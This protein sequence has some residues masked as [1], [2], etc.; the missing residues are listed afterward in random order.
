[1]N[2][3]ITKKILGFKDETQTFIINAKPSDTNRQFEVRIVDELTLVDFTDVATAI[4]YYGNNSMDIIAYMN[5]DKSSFVIPL[6]E[7]LS[8]TGDLQCEIVL[9][10]SNEINIITTNTFVIRVKEM[11]GGCNC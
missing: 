5:R 8:S 3:I 2:T 1:M 9:K 6:T 11:K 7:L 10:D 4:L